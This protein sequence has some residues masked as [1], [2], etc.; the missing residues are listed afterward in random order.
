MILFCMNIYPQQME[1]NDIKIQKKT[2]IYKTV[3][4]TRI[5][6]DLYQTI[7]NTELKPAIIWIHGGALIFGSRTGLQEEQMKFYLTAGYSVISIDYRL[8][9]ETRL[10]GIVEDIKDVIQWVRANGPDLLGIDST[11]IF[12]IGHSAGA[13]L[14]LMS[15]YILRNPPQGI[16]SFYG[17]GSILSEWFNKPDS[18]YRT[19]NLISKE[20]ATKLIRDSITTGFQSDDR[21]DLY[22]YGRQSGVWPRLIS[23]HDPTIEAEWF[24]RYC[25]I[26]NINSNYPPALLLHGDKDLDV[27][28]IESVLMDKELELKKINH[29]FIKMINYGHGFD[30]HDG[31]KNPDVYKVFKEVIVFLNN[32]R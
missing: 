28:F 25:P 20:K 27:P 3:G 5:H 9:P 32:C 17:Y 21:N 18:F 10:P 24:K 1:A 26:K 31:L 19:K 15:G 8:A 12:I 7:A 22:Y 11:K 13:Y 29:K 6:A 4:K 23:N 2:F 30:Y 14:A 16:V